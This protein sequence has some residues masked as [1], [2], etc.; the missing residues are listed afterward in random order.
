MLQIHYAPPPKRLF[1]V[2]NCQGNLKGSIGSCQITLNNHLD[3]LRQGFENSMAQP[4]A[5]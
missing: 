2:F 5:L 3:Q 1:S 4:I